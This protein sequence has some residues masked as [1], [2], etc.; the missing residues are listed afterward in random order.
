MKAI[1]FF[2]II[3]SCC[4]L[5]ADGVIDGE[6][7]SPAVD[8]ISSIDGCYGGDFILVTNQII[9]NSAVADTSYLVTI[10][11]KKERIILWNWGDLA[12]QLAKEENLDSLSRIALNDGFSVI[13]KG[14]ACRY[15]RPLE[16]MI[17]VFV[18]DAET[19][20]MIEIQTMSVSVEVFFCKADERI[21]IIFDGVDEL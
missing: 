2:V 18:R 16:T 4:L 3:V 17:K 19:K 15:S 10:E 21:E 11:E 20:E 7:M 6:G 13:V 9:V 12:N 14:R 1:L 8:S 5:G